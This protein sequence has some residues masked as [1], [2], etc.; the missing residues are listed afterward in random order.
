[1]L[2]FIFLI[3]EKK[4]DIISLPNPKQKL[5]LPFLHQQTLHIQCS[6][7]SPPNLLVP[8]YNLTFALIAVLGLFPPDHSLH[9]KC[10]N[11]LANFLPHS[12]AAFN[13]VHAPVVE[14]F[15]PF[16]FF[17]S[18]HLSFHFLPLFLTGFYLSAHSLN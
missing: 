13:P 15:F 2:G 17:T 10:E 8:H 9:P 3:S 4:K 1:M 7:S 18:S 14:T 6:M 16:A 5:F 11:R 12:M